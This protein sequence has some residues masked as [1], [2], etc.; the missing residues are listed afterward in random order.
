M[1]VM[2]MMVMMMV[3]MMRTPLDTLG[4]ALH[5]PTQRHG[6]VSTSDDDDDGDDD[7]G[8]VIH[9]SIYNLHRVYNAHSAC[10]VSAMCTEHTV[11]RLC[12][13]CASVYWTP[14][15]QHSKHE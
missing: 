6:M 8:D 4:V 11:Y 12:A 1:M 15:H 10:S 5:I 9:I 3:M 13:V 2:M 14:G 7:D